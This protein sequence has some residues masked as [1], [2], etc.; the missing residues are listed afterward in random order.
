VIETVKSVIGVHGVLAMFN[1]V[2]VSKSR[3]APFP[4][5]LL[6]LVWLVLLCRKLATVPSIVLTVSWA[7]WNMDLVLPLAQTYPAKWVGAKLLVVIS[8]L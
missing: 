2:M 3:P 7:P 4:F 5:N 8:L 1:V 6:V